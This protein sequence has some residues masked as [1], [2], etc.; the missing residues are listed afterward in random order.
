MSIEGSLVLVKPGEGRAIPGVVFKIYA[1]ETRGAF[2]IVEHPLAPRILIPPHT[3]EAADQVSYVLEGTA[4]MR[5]GDDDFV[6][7]PGA[8]VVKPRAV[9]HT[10]WNPTDA[11][12]RIMEIT[13]P[14]NF[15]GFFEGMGEI[16]AHPGPERP[17][18]LRDLGSRYATSFFMDW[19][20]DL[21]ARH[22]LK[23]LGS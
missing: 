6:C 2:S 18:R 22:G 14:G 12:M 23:L 8:Y 19:V 4:G 7:E 21:I 16:F 17:Q 10:L 9:P 11:P 20:P 15:E 13:T 5:I 3:H 1:R